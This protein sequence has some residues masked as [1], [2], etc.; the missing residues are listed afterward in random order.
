M[1]K[2]L[3]YLNNQFG[4]NTQSVL[5]FIK[6]KLT[7]KNSDVLVLTGNARTGKTLFCYFLQYL[8]DEKFL[9]ID[10]MRIQPTQS[11]GKKTRLYFLKFNFQLS[12]KNNRNFIVL[13]DFQYDKEI[14]FDNQ[15]KIINKL[16]ID[17]ICTDQIFSLQK[18]NYIVI[19]T[20]NCKFSDE[21]IHH[22]NL[23]VFENEKTEFLSW[24]LK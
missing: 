9:F 5:K 7:N 1:Q 2:I 13:D 3:K 11:Y 17:I 14:E 24:L 19:N 10:G 6:T 23:S 8:I 4:D 18:Q 21:L 20:D 22:G 12:E 15:L 16:S